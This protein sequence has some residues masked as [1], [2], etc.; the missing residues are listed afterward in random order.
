MIGCIP[1]GICWPLQASPFLGTCLL[2][3]RGRGRIRFCHGEC[4]NWLGTSEVAEQ[5]AP[6]PLLSV[7]VG[8]SVAFALAVG[9]VVVGATLSPWAALGAVAAVAV[10]LGM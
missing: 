7:A 8:A 3:K 5:A 1:K 6:V 10:C 4:M 2:P 9:F